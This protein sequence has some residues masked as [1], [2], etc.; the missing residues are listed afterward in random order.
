L[1]AAIESTQT[2]R[3]WE[4]QRISFEAAY[5]GKRMVLYLYLPTSGAPP[6]QT[7]IYWPGANARNLNSID[8]YSSYMDFVVKNGRAV[9]FPAYEGTFERGDR[10]PLPGF[11]TTAYRD[12]VIHGVNDLRRSIDYL[13]TRPDIDHDAI[14]YFGH[15]WGALNG[16]SVLA[17]EPRIRAAI[18]YVGF[19]A[20]V[21]MNPEVDP[22]N[23]LPRV[24]MP[25]LMLSSEFDGAVPLENA[26]R[27]FELIGTPSTDKK[28]VIAPGGHFV[29]RD[30]LIRETLDWLDARLGLSGS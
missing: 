3:I 4:R 23:A 18:M 6:Y 10:S 28:H 1:N 12:S 14:A 8:E 5:A 21:P 2:T 19:L 9:A 16:A 13:A 17:Q 15:S 24:H 11:P 22:V 25:V 26:R 20:P 29:P 27:F 7:V 30:V